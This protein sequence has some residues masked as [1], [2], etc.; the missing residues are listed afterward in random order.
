VAPWSGERIGVPARGL[1]LVDTFDDGNEIL[2]R[3]FNGKEESA[4]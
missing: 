4:P 3:R 2:G 1:A